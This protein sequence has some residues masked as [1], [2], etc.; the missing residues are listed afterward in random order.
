MGVGYSASP[1]HLTS[2]INWSSTPGRRVRRGE[3]KLIDLFAAGR[4]DG[5]IVHEG[6][7]R[8]TSPSQAT[9]L[10]WRDRIARK[11]RDQLGKS[12]PGTKTPTSSGPRTS[13]PA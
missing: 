10:A 12:C 7:M 13:E 8:F 11:Y 5:A 4:Y 3:D 1:L 2:H 9:I 6:P